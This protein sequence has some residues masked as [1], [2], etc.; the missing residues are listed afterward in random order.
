MKKISAALLALAV[1]NVSS[2]AQT[3]NFFVNAFNTAAEVTNNAG[4]NGANNG[5]GNWF[6]SAFISGV[7][8]ST[9]DSSNNPSSGSFKVTTQLYPHSGSNYS[10]YVL[11]DGF[12]TFT[13]D[14]YNLYT[15]LSFDIRFDPSSVTRTNDDGTVDFGAMRAG[16]WDNW[17]QDWF[18]YFSISAT[19]GLGQPN[20]GWTHISIPINQS[21]TFAFW[22]ALT[23][24]SDVLIGIDAG[25]GGNVINGL[26]VGGDPLSLAGGEPVSAN[27]NM[28]GQQIFWVDN[29][30]FLGPIGGIVHPP[31][32][33]SAVKSQPALRA[34]IGS[35]SIYARSQL[36]TVNASES[37]IGAGTTYPVTYS[38][39]LSDFPSV[40]QLQ[41][42]LEL[43]PGPAYT[44]NAGADYGNTNCLWLQILSDGAGGYTA[45]VSWKTNAPNNNPGHT[46]LSIASSTSPAGTWTLTFTSPTGGTLSAPGTN[47]V[48]FTINDPNLT[49]DWQNPCVLVIG[50][51]PNGVSAA[52]GLPSD[53]T[54]ISVTGVAGGSIVDDFTT[55]TS[56][57]PNWTLLNSDNTNTL[58]LVTKSTPLWVYW[59]LPD[60]GFRSGL[61]V[62]TNITSGASGPWVLPQYYNGYFDLPAPEAQGKLVWD[63]IPSDCLPTVDGNAQFGQPLSPNA[64]FRLSNPPPPF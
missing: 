19:N 29:I 50:N 57:D 26:N 53:Y 8:D 60:T 33:V 16:T 9:V 20:T 36:T 59:T 37:W 42:H 64:F 46:E 1:F 35:A 15:N 61:G 45:N 55:A 34:F 18:Y 31:P 52:E 47:N 30:Q 44:G 4:F 2:Q 56:I 17:N 10:Q 23:S 58:V 3:T 11:F 7:W 14:M 63:L 21:N 38:F 39:T 62:S 40:N 5:W 27:T 49:T 41:A 48:P 12:F 43:I 13:A 28:T 54:H 6:G 51:Q 25:G 24:M 22:P 32:V